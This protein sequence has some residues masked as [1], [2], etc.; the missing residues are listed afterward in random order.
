MNRSMW[1]GLTTAMGA[2][3]IAGATVLVR[4]GM[5]AKIPSPT[6]GDSNVFSPPAATEVRLPAETATGRPES[7]SLPPSPPLFRPGADGVAGEGPDLDVA[8]PT[9]AEEM[10]LARDT[11][12]ARQTGV[13]GGVEGGVPGGVLG[14]VVAGSPEPP[15]SRH[16]SVARSLAPRTAPT[17]P[18]KSTGI[19]SWEIKKDE[20]DYR[21]PRPPID[22]EGYD[23]IRDNPFLAAAANPLSTFSIDVDTASYSNVRRFLTGGQLPP[24]D[25]VRIEEL[26]NYFRYD[27]PEPDGDEPFA[28][29][30][31]V[32][33]SPWAPD[34]RLVLVGLRGRSL[35]DA[36]VPPRNLT[37]L[38]DVSGSMNSPDKLPLLKQAMS[39]LVNTL[40]EEDHVSIVVY[41]GAS[42]LVL[43][44]TSGAQ[45]G[46][47]EEALQSLRAGGSTA[48]GAGIELAYRVADEGYVE[49]GINRVILAT[50]GD[51]NVGLSS[52]GD[53]LR[54][55]E[56]KR[57][58]GVFLSVL[59]FGQGNL[60]DSKMEKLADHGNGN[61]AYIDS[62]REA[63]K[64]LV[65]EAGATL[66]TIAKDVKVQVEF[67]P[68]RVAAYRLIGYENRA[69][70]A[71]DFA[72]DRKDAG[73]IGAGHTVT[74]LY[75]VVPVGVEIDLPSVDPLKYQSAPSSSGNDEL[76][77]V[78]LRHK[79]PDGDRSRLRSVAVSDLE[80]GHEPSANLRFASAVAAFGMLLRESEHRGSATWDQVIDLARTA[81]GDDPDGHRTEF[82]VL[83]RNAEQ[84]TATEQVAISR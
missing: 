70:R 33:T 49:G 14:G 57:K 22:R 10:T 52:E 36:S 38:L 7:E 39:L 61:Y 72:D 81:I 68:A 31:E 12:L 18:A 23:H 53:L 62:V 6:P 37:F 74:A 78:K 21:V 1:L 69:L 26:V 82:L 42:G 11:V 77:T 48:G 34:H 75:E 73:E 2:L 63:R 80:P 64:V 71:E 59:G 65:T 32:A 44:P 28:V 19:A 35:D 83:A 45:K 24:K 25:A 58:S 4:D 5:R 47:I 13:P 20:Q 60:Q 43:P 55:I 9:L 16:D 66:V 56:E 40:R 30:T 67:N 79:A 3:L 54:L 29:T 15:R 51:F 8:G 84:L 50:D 41:A 76:L 46:T 27:Y 17:A